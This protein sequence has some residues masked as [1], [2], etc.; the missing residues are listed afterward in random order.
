[1][2]AEGDNG[3]DNEEGQRSGARGLGVE[4]Q[5]QEVVPTPVATLLRLSVISSTND[6][7]RTSEPFPSTFS[8][9]T[10]PKVHVETEK[11]L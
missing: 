3:S 6:L 10:P 7:N 2:M 9:F 8:K 1:M 4:S 5:C 11:C